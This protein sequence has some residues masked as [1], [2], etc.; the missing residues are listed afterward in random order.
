MKYNNLE[1]EQINRN[2]M[3]MISPLLVI[4]F[5]QNRL[6]TIF[7]FYSK[8]EWKIIFHLRIFWLAVTI[9]QFGE[10]HWTRLIEFVQSVQH[11]IKCILFVHV[12][13][14]WQ[15]IL[16]SFEARVFVGDTPSY[17][18]IAIG[19]FEADSHQILKNFGLCLLSR[20]GPNFT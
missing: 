20:D 19:L 10:G 12:L 9:S 6:D 4:F 11:P 2:L 13:V 16:W 18:A 1:K 5:N 15:G 17:K 8:S 7:E 14:K 3:S